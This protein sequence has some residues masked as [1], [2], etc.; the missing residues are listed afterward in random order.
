VVGVSFDTARRSWLAHGEGDVGGVKNS[1]SLDVSST[2]PM[3]SGLLL[4]H[5]QTALL[6]RATCRDAI[7]PE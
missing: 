4:N 7:L 6:I 3:I 2:G 1:S 5:F